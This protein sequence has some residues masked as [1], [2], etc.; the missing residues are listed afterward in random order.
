MQV[1]EKQRI[2]FE[3]RLFRDKEF[4]KQCGLMDYSLLMIF[5]RRKDEEE[6]EFLNAQRSKMSFYIK[7]E[8]N[9]DEIEME[10]VP[11]ECLFESNPK[12]A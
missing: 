10:E 9:G 2:D 7:R 6:G 8:A 3:R 4:L 12:P 5:L 1:E 11:P